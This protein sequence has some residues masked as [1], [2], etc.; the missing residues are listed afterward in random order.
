MINLTQKAMRSFSDVKGQFLI[1]GASLLRLLGQA[2]AEKKKLF[3]LIVPIVLTPGPKIEFLESGVVSS[4]GN[5]GIEFIRSTR[6]H[7]FICIVVV[8]GAAMPRFDA[9]RYFDV[10]RSEGVAEGDRE[11]FQ[12]VVTA[13][14]GD[15]A[16]QAVQI[17]SE[18]LL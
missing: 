16:G 2:L 3:G 6:S 18:S 1:F 10:R 7:S 15:A 4:A 14:P 5:Q 12:G 11:W 9:D 8:P 13:A 17:Q